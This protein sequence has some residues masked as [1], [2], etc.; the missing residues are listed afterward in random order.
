MAVKCRARFVYVFAAQSQLNAVQAIAALAFEPAA[1][2][3]RRH[4]TT[5][6]SKNSYGRANTRQ[7]RAAGL[8]HAKAKYTNR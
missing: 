2:G 5:A 7:V 6:S 3:L 4:Q 8:E 1:G